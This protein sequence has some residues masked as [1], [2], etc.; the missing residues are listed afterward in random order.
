MALKNPKLFGLD[1]NRAFADVRDRLIALNNINLPPNDIEIIFGSQAAGAQRLDWRSFSRLIEPLHETLDRFS[2]DSSIFN[3]LVSTRAGTEGVLFGNLK[4]NGALS[5]SAIRYRY[6][7]GFGPGATV[8]FAD[9]STSRVSAWSSSDPRATN[10]DFTIQGRAKISYGARIKIVSGGKL[11]FG[12][13]ETA[14]PAVTGPRLQ[15]SIIPQTKEFASEFPTH[16]ITTTIGGSSVNFYA[17]KGIPIIFKGFFRSLDATIELT[18]LINNTPA[19]WK[20]VETGD[21]SRYSNYSNIGS[22][23]TSISYRSSISRE[24]F[25]QFYYNPD[26]IKEITINSAN[27]SELPAVKFANAIKLN[28]DYNNLRNFPDLNFIAPNITQLLLR[29]NPFYLSETESERKLQSTSPG[30]GT[31]TNTVLDKIP[32]TLRELYLEG[33]FGGSITQNIFAKRFPQLVNFDLA[34][35]GGVSFHPDSADSTNQLPNVA[36]TV[37]TYSVASNDFRAID[38]SAQGSGGIFNITQLENLVTLNISNNYSLGGAFSIAINNTVIKTINID[39]TALPFPTGVAGKSSLE[40]FT[41]TYNRGLDKLVDLEGGNSVSYVFN[42][43]VNLSTLNLYGSNLNSTRFPVFTNPSLASLTLVGGGIKGGAPNGDETY[44]IPN[45]TFQFATNLNTLYIS[46]SDLLT[47]PIESDAFANLT[48]LS[49]IIYNSSRR[50][51]GGIPSLLGNPN[52]V[53]INLSFNAFVGS[54]PN[55]SSNTSVYSAD[56]SFNQLDGVIP[57]Y[58]NL[59]NLYELYLHSNKLVNIGKFINLPKLR[60][61]YIQDNLIGQVGEAKIP[62]LSDCPSLRY[63]IAYNNKFEQ[64]EPGAFA[65]LI[66]IRL[67]DLSDNPFTELALEKMLEDLYLNWQ[68]INRGSVTINLRG[69]GVIESTTTLEYIAV[70][71]TKGWSITID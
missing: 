68:T 47:S 28:F 59:S 52:L 13:Q 11:E 33:T 44:V 9:I 32:T 69:C 26:N 34:R 27:I 3:A 31:T 42:N 63:F 15:T 61:L 70:L 54:P 45:S 40:T 16:K 6:I 55:L 22:T 65:N 41:A 46:S 53:Y 29:R 20:I 43:C 71:R 24:R 51:T 37:E 57:T 50:T 19:S 64:Y 36:D 60:Y 21:A 62:D 1:V 49:N 12:T 18:Q 58:Q 39:S 38:T 17:M 7:D 66:Q 5:G 2:K 56:F 67:I 30:S 25:I 4:I 14:S 8:K 48:S 10:S 23:S 35:G